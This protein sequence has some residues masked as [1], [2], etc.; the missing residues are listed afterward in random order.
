L[1]FRRIITCEKTGALDGFNLEVGFEK[2]SRY[3][4]IGT[5]QTLRT[6]TE[7]LHICVLC[8]P[9]TDHQG[10]QGGNGI[11]GFP[12]GQLIGSIEA[13]LI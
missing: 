3:P 5:T 6:G 12:T 9:T 7:G 10:A 11:L 4:S 2:R 1:I 8:C 13:S